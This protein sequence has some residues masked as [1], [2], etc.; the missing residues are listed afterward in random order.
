[1]IE[2]QM[3]ESRFDF[4]GGENK[5]FIVEMTKALENAGYTYGGVIGDGI[6][7]G[8]YMLIFRKAGVKSKKVAARIYIRANCVAL[9]LFLSGVT[10][11]SRFI[12]SAPDYIKEVFVGKSGS[13][14]RCR[15]EECRFRKSYEIG[16]EKIDKCNGEVFTFESPTVERIPDYM[17]LFHEFYPS[18]GGLTR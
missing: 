8:K 4:V 6:C 1:M 10:G 12:E 2:K 18:R 17:A 9:R 11:H 13:C 15:G 16:G 5:S 3:T 14:S 7:W